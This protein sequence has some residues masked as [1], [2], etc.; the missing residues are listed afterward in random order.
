MDDNPSLSEK[1]KQRY[2]K[3]YSG[4]FY[5]RFVKGRW[6]AVYGAVY[7]SYFHVH[8]LGAKRV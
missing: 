4:V 1:V 7:S 6:V 5:E 2:E 3:L 8:F